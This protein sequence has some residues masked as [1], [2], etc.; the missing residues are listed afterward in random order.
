MGAG[1]R[2]QLVEGTVDGGEREQRTDAVEAEPL[3]DVGAEAMLLVLG[4]DAEE[5]RVELVLGD[6]ADPL[7]GA[8]TRDMP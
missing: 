1:A 2:L 3:L 7:S 6:G 8:A 4:E 5:A